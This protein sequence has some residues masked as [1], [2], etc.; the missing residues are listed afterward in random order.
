MGYYK[1]MLRTLGWNEERLVTRANDMARHVFHYR[2]YSDPNT[3]FK[4]GSVDG[5][6]WVPP[7]IMSK[8]VGMMGLQKVKH[9]LTVVHKLPKSFQE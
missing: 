3:G 5:Q 7:P 9:L 2:G 8:A 1:S 4:G 6:K